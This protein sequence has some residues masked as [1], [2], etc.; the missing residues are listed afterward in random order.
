MKKRSYERPTLNE[1]GSFETITKGASCPGNAD[2]TFPVG[3]PS[4]QFTCFS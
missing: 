4:S 3:T 2:A 1:I